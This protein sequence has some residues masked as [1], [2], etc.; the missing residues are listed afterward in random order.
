MTTDLFATL[1]D[2][3]GQNAAVLRERERTL[4]DN[5]VSPDAPLVLFGAG[6]LGQKILKGARK[7]GVTVLAFADNNP[8]RQGTMVDEVPV[9]SLAE[10]AN[11]FGT[12]ATFVSAV[13]MD[14]DWGAFKARREELRSLGC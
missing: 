11:R 13:F 9:F 10:A 12:S 8:Q 6:G 7:L 4:W 2:L 14:S 5:R 3:L 1:E